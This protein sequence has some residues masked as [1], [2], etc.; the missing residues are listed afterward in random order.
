MRWSQGPTTKSSLLLD[1]NRL[2]YYCYHKNHIQKEMYI[3]V[4]DKYKEK[5]WLQQILPSRWQM[6]E[7]KLHK[8][9]VCM[10]IG[11]ILMS[12]PSKGGSLSGRPAL[13]TAAWGVCSRTIKD[14]FNVFV[15][16]KFTMERK[17]RSYTGSSIFNDDKKASRHSLLSLK[18][19]KYQEFRENPG[20]ILE[21]KLKN[22][23]KLLPVNWKEVFSILV[24][25]DLIWA[26]TL[27]DKMNHVLLQ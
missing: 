22:E 23:Y 9:T 6:C 19:W 16:K 24:E 20:H 12:L 26:C 5:G 4:T 11:A 10:V 8:K 25:R 14:Q 1:L 7:L 3:V 17:T 21:N 15:R 2:D 27:W 13:Y 18:K